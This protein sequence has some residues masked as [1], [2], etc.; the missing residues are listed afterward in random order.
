VRRRSSEAPIALAAFVLL[1]SPSSA[2]VIFQRD[3]DDSEDTDACGSPPAGWDSWGI[4]SGCSAD[5]DGVT[6][7]AGEVSSPGRG[8]TGKSL[9]LWRAGTLFEGYSGG[10]Y[11]GQSSNF[12]PTSQDFYVRWTM[13]IPAG[14]TLDFTDAGSNYQ[15]LFRLNMNGGEGELYVNINTPYADQTVPAGGALQIAPFLHTDPVLGYETTNYT[16]LGPSDLAPLFDGEWHCYE[17]HVDSLAGTVE[18]WVDGV[19]RHRNAALA[20]SAQ[21]PQW[22]QHFGFGNR[23]SG[24]V[25]QDSW[26]A[27]EFDDLVIADAYVGPP[28]SAAPRPS[29][30]T[31]LNVN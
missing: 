20:M 6:H 29:A 21:S 11:C 26:Q 24:S 13:R 27:W 1:A 14:A 12:S 25:M 5:F 19:S 15:K 18:L 3:F 7:P 28:G 23:A 22:I 17:L 9:K 30:P 16:V 2:A 8:G 4:E 31:G 10:V